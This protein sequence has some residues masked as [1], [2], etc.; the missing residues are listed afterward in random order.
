MRLKIERSLFEVILVFEKFEKNV[1]KRKKKKEKE[2][3]EEH[4]KYKIN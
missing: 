1:R 3:V 4:K 2:K